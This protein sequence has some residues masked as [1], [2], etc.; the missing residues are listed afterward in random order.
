MWN[1]Y[2]IQYFY[3]YTF[4]RNNRKAKDSMHVPMQSNAEPSFNE[5]YNVLVIQF[6]G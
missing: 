6:S 2:N 1:I 5:K 4:A 3:K